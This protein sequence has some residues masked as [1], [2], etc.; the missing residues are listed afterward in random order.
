MRNNLLVAMALCS[1]TSSTLPLWASENW[2][3]PALTFVEPN[4]TPDET[5]G[6][7]TAIGKTTGELNLS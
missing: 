2:P 6:G 4:L 1:A 5:G 7:A 3:D